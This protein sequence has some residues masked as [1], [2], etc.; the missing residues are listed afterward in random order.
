MRGKKDVTTFPDKPV[1]WIASLFRGLM[2]EY[3][4]DYRL[5][6]RKICIIRGKLKNFKVQLLRSNALFLC[7][8]EDT[9]SL[10]FKDQR[11]YLKIS[12]FTNNILKSVSLYIWALRALLFLSWYF[13]SFFFGM[14]SLS[15]QWGSTERNLKI[16]LSAFSKSSRMSILSHVDVYFLL[17]HLS[18]KVCM[19]VR[20]ESIA[21]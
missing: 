8:H 1:S 21:P 13:V 10:R 5:Y 7:R 2:K 20:S 18:I 14:M 17:K 6:T 12:L 9:S 4:C 19:T 11:L 3:S 16:F 15:G